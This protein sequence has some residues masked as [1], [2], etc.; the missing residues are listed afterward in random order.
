MRCW[1]RTPPRRPLPPLQ[2]E[3]LPPPPSPGEVPPLPLPPPRPRR[4]PQLPRKGRLRQ[5]QLRRY[6]REL[7]VGAL[8]HL[9]GGPGRKPKTLKELRSWVAPSPLLP[10]VLPPSPLPLCEYPGP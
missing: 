5:R 1:V 7:P 8:G 9:E 10:I 4:R 6:P 2:Q 3:P